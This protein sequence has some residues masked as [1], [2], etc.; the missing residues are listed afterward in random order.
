MAENTQEAIAI[1]KEG[2]VFEA[3]ASS[4]FTVQMDNPLSGAGFSPMELVL[5]GLA[6]CTG[7][8]VIDILRKKRQDV[9]AL[10]VRVKGIRAGEHPRKYTALQ[11]LYVVTGR[12]VDSEAVRRSIELSETKYCAVAATLR[13]TAPI[14]TE[15]EI[16]EAA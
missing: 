16:R 8:D 15:F 7:M 2:L 14:E 4:G 12:K 10:Q 11:V 5:V 9:T 13:G 3:T 6:G 1:W